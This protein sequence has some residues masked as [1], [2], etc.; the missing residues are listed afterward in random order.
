MI[1]NWIYQLL[2]GRGTRGDESRRA[3][4]K[5]REVGRGTRGDES[6]RARC[7]EREEDIISRYD[8]DWLVAQIQE[9]FIGYSKM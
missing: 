1:Y 9:D 7:K 6:R 4:C 2:F 5:E 8:E 3:R